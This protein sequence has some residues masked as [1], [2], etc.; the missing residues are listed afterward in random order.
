MDVFRCCVMEWS[1]FEVVRM[2]YRGHVVAPTAEDFRRLAG[3]T[4][5]TVRD[6]R[7]DDAAMRRVYKAL[8]QECLDFGE[9]SLRDFVERYV[10]ASEA[11]RG[12]TLA[13]E[14][15]KQI[16]SRRKFLRGVFRSLCNPYIDAAPVDGPD[17]NSFDDK[18]LLRAFFP[19]GVEGE[20]AID[21]LLT[22]L[23]TFNVIKP[24]NPDAQRSRD[25]TPEDIAVSLNAMIALVDQLKGD[26]A[27]TELMTIPKAFDMTSD[28]LHDM[29]RSIDSASERALCSPVWFRFLLRDIVDACRYVISPRDA[30]ESST[31]INSLSMPG[32]WIDDADNGK[33]RFWIF[34][35]NFHMAFCYSF[36]GSCWHLHPYEFVF[37][38]KEGELTGICLFISAEGERQILFSKTRKLR[39]NELVITEFERVEVTESVFFNELRFSSDILRSGSR[40]WFNWTKFVRLND[41]DAKFRRF[42]AALREIYDRRSLQALCLFENHGSFFT[43][44][45]NALV[46]M[47]NDYLYLW[48]SPQP[49][50]F[51]LS[52]ESNGFFTY[53]DEYDTQ[54]P[55]LSFLHLEVSEEH[56]LYAIPRHAPSNR[57]VSEHEQRLLE[58]AASTTMDD[59]ISIYTDAV[60]NRKSICFTRFSLLEPL[61]GE[62]NR[63]VLRIT[64][65]RELFGGRI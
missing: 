46:G 19:N 40:S 29:L 61:D 50:R 17:Y 51:L 37:P 38:T 35:E 20:A 56:P 11:C 64:S 10:A 1:L 31:A 24:L 18:R 21:P 26:F 59:F 45:T 9:P 3:V 23:I 12:V 32:I 44:V 5:E 2:V 53:N 41:N 63:G 28:I 39:D 30:S 34:P 62:G 15:R 52:S 54:E 65:R 43:D 47:D 22:M 49:G 7:D 27:S 6:H 58:A 8:N 48:D 57:K 42:S 16:G 36:D 33:S 13:W 25:L 60:M 55:V 4:F 14:G